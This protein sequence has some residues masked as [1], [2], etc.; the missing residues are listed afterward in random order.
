MGVARR[1]AGLHNPIIVKGSTSRPLVGLS[2]IFRRVVDAAHRVASSDASVLVVGESGTGKETLA[3]SLHAASRR[4][5][6]G[7]VA[8]DCASLP[9]QLV[10]SE[11]FGHEVGAFTGATCRRV[12]RVETAHGGTLFLDHVEQ[13]DP[14][15]QAALLRTLESGEVCA[16]GSMHPR[17][18]DF[19]VVASAPPDLRARVERG[20]FRDDLFWR[21]D[22]VELE[23]P[24]LRARVEDVRPLAES[25]VENLRVR[26]FSPAAI[27]TLEIHDWPGNVRE[28]RNVCEAAASTAHEPAVLVDDLPASLRSPSP[29][30]PISPG[31]DATT[32]AGTAFR[33]QVHDFE[34]RLVRNALDHHLWDL[35]KAARELALTRHQIRYL[36]R[37]LDVRRPGA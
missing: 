27:A 22:V 5:R 29:P 31:D 26:R 1:V 32:D 10:A 23:L 6:G 24:P 2:S 21:L 28:L 37:K 36:M 30:Q 20:E 13:L 11:L 35:G 25:F 19:R 9:S 4:A 15:V 33:D 8:I 7:F 18:L 12:G 34:R 14:R 16:L 17:R 3:R